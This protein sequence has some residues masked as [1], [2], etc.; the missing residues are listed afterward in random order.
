MIEQEIR[1]DIDPILL[2]ER[3]S[4]VFFL[5]IQSLNLVLHIT[6]L[7]RHGTV[8]LENRFVHGN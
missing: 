8:N 5:L 2:D 6:V 4:L 7:Q 1:S 3:I